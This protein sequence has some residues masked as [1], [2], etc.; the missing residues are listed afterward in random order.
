MRVGRASWGSTVSLV[1]FCHHSQNTMKSVY[2]SGSLGKH[3]VSRTSNSAAYEEE[4]GDGNGPPKFV[5]VIVIAAVVLIVFGVGLFLLSVSC[6]PNYRPN[7]MYACSFIN[8][9]MLTRESICADVFVF[10]SSNMVAQIVRMQLKRSSFPKNTNIY[11]KI[12]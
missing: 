7:F 12:Q 6:L 10:R 5:I 2:Q 3:S 9:N 8:K 11:D 4:D 1:T